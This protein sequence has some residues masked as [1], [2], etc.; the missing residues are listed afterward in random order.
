[1]TFLKRN[2]TWRFWVP[3]EIRKYRKNP[4]SGISK[5]LGAD[6]YISHEKRDSLSRTYFRPRWKETCGD[7]RTSRGV[8]G[9]L[10]DLSCQPFSDKEINLNSFSYQSPIAPEAPNH[11]G[12]WMSFVVRP[13]GRKFAW[14]SSW[15]MR[16]YPMTWRTMFPLESFVRTSDGYID[17]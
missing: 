2:E 14:K 7:H 11:V 13:F 4:P 10:R 16:D 8:H 12:V 9:S 1:M 3:L 6:D 15:D 5:F 17:F